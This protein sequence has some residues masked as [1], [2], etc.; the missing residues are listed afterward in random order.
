MGSKVFHLFSQLWNKGPSNVSSQ[1]DVVVVDEPPAAGAAAAVPVAPVAEAGARKRSPFIE[2]DGIFIRF[3][4]DIIGIF[5]T[6]DGVDW[7]ITR[8]Y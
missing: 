2:F 3:Q 8:I 7:D 4:W 5:K 6:F 1:D